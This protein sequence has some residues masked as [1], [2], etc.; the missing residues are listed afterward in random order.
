MFQQKG[1][2]VLSD[3]TMFLFGIGF[4]NTIQGKYLQG[5]KEDHGIHCVEMRDTY[6]GG[7]GGQN[8]FG[9]GTIEPENKEI[10]ALTIS[11]RKETCLLLPNTFCQILF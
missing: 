4:K 3:E 5:R 9:Y 1:G 11:I 2:H 10:L 7:E 8:T 6:Q